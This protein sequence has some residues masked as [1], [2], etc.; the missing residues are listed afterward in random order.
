MGNAFSNCN[1]FVVGVAMETAAINTAFVKLRNVIAVE[2]EEA[3]HA[4]ATR[5]IANGLK[6]Q[7]AVS[8][9]GLI[10]TNMPSSVDGCTSVTRLNPA[11]YLRAS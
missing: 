1:T 7:V 3:K 11:L 10:K 8:R 9:D 6:C 5:R 4:L 2:P